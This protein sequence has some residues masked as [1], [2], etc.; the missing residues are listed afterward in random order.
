M[1]GARNWLMPVFRVLFAKNDK[2]FRM[3]FN[4]IQST[5]QEENI[6]WTVRETAD[7][8]DISRV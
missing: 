4:C 1:C 8:T 6:I 3:Y 7:A 2:L 5:H